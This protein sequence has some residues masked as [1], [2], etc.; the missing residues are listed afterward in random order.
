MNYSKKETSKKQKSL[1]SKKKKV[2]KKLSVIF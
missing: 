2:G 1:R